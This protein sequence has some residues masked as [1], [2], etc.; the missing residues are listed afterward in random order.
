MKKLLASLVAL[1]FVLSCASASEETNASIKT[2]V[3]ASLPKSKKI[4]D[5]LFEKRGFLVT[6]W[7]AEQGL[8][9]DCRLE[10]LVCGEGGCYKKWEFGKKITRELVLYVHRDLQYYHIKPSKDF[11]MDALIEQGFAKNLV[12]IKG[13][14]SEKSNTITAVAF[15]VYPFSS[16]S[17][18][19]K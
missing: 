8:F 10:S 13:E 19:V 17:S 2:V 11:D 1:L 15:E 3:S 5:T 12:V 18:P 6:K 4:A 14:Y 7:C 16:N 9:A